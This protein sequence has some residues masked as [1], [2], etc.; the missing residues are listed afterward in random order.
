MLKIKFKK[1]SEHAKLPTKG[2]LDAACFDVYAA[3][4]RIER[5]NKMIVGLGFSTEIPKGYKGILVPRSGISKHN[6]VLANS[7]GIIDADYRGE[8][9]AVFRCL[10]DMIYQPLPFGVGDR[11][12]QIYFEKILDVAFVETEELSDTER[13]DGGFGSTGTK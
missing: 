9:M 6:W 10:G 2:S 4:V 5:P 7:I 8:W 1:L 13:N 12:A 3:S 11:C